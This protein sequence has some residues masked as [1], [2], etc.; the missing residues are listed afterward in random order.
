[1]AVLGENE[2]RIAWLYLAAA[3]E[4]AQ[5]V[6]SM[7]SK[8]SKGLM[9]EYFFTGDFLQKIGHRNGRCFLPPS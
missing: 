7:Q 2:L 1:M 4:S 6:S 5:A 8:K 3:E 9:F